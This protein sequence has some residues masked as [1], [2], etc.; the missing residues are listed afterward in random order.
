MYVTLVNV[1][2]KPEHIEEFVEATAANHEGSVHEPGN[3]RFD[4]LQSIDDPT[5]FVLYESYGNEGD[6]KDHKGTP[7]YAAWRDAVADWLVEPRVGVRYEGLFPA[8]PVS[9]K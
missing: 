2:V 5:R 6:A 3:F 7:H 9:G 4:V 8:A 1:H